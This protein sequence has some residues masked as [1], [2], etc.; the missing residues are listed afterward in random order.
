MDRVEKELIWTS[1]I[2]SPFD[3]LRAGSSTSS[4]GTP[5]QAGQAL[6]D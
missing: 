5:G 6:R 4:H 2:L 1:L 3:K